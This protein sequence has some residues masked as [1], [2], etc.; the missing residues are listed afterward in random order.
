M[1]K[2]IKRIKEKSEEKVFIEGVNLVKTALESQNI[3]I[4]KILATE[5]FIQR[6]KGFFEMIKKRGISIFFITEKLAKLVSD[7]VTPQGI[8]AVAVFKMKTLKDLNIDKPDLVVIADRIQDPGNLGTII[9]VVE[10]LGG[11]A[12]FITPGTC[13]PLSSK[14]LRA[15]VGSIFFLPIVKAQ[16]EEIKFFI[17]K[18]NLKLIV[19]DPQA[20]RL[21]FEID[22]REPL[23][24][25][26]GNEST[27]VSEDLRKIPHSSF[28][29]PHVGKT[30]SLNV[31]VSAAIFLYEILRGRL[32]RKIYDMI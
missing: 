12:V 3:F 7:T 22:F 29:I 1:I 11:Q 25:A 31:A 27:G 16:I 26:F 28:K 6:N 2:E 8:F 19:T 21:S 13:N 15:S 4:E 9:R 20:E 17:N 24:V 14:V 32:K 23:A 5:G 18:N 30:E 10:A